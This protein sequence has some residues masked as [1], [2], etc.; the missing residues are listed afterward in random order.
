MNNEDEARMVV[1]KQWAAKSYKYVAPFY[2]GPPPP[3][4]LR[5]KTLNIGSVLLMNGLSNSFGVTCAHCVDGFLTRSKSEPNILLR[6]GDMYVTDFESR[7]IDLDKNLDLCSFRIDPFELRL[8]KENGEFLTWHQPVEMTENMSVLIVGFP[9]HV[10][11]P[12]SELNLN[13]GSISILEQTRRG[14]LSSASFIIELDTN[15]WVFVQNP[16]QI[17]IEEVEHFGGLSGCPI[18]IQNGL[19]S[20][21]AGIVYESPVSQNADKIEY[22]YIK[23]RYN[24]F[25]MNGEILRS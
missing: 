14:N 18:F 1:F 7:I 9:G 8:I 16:S 24:V 25:G 19:D 6:I 17:K 23:S 5:N 11:R 21:L 13:I 4:D 10:F 20:L 22:P 3:F 15:D 12:S 2:Y